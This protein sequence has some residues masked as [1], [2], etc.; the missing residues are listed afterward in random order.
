MRLLSSRLASARIA[1]LVLIVLPASA[2]VI[3]GMANGYHRTF[4]KGTVA[5]WVIAT[6][7]TLGVAFLGTAAFGLSLLR[8][9]T[10]AARS[11]SN[12]WLFLAFV[13]WIVWAYFRL[14]QYAS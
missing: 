8:T 4:E 13:L 10:A 7:L 12:R 14:N 2:I 3:W 5:T 1:A 9:N 6:Q 11:R